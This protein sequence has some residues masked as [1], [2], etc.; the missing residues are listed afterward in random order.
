MN[1]RVLW[2]LPALGLGAGIAVWLVRTGPE[3]ARVTLSQTAIPVEVITAEAR[4]LSPVATGYGI[5]RPARSWH[6]V[7]SVRGGIMSMHP[8]LA[9]GRFIA[10]GAEVLRIDPSEYLLAL[11]EAQADLASLETEAAQIAAER[12]NLD[13][14][15]GIERARL[16]LAEQ[17]LARTGQL[18]A[19]GS[20]PQARLDEQLRATL[21]FR[22][23]V[24]ELENALA[25]LPVQRARLEAQMDRTRVRIARAERDLSLTTLVAPFDM[26]VTDRQVD[27]FQFVSAGQPLLTGEGIAQA[28]IVAQIPIDGFRRIVAA[29]LGAGTLAPLDRMH[30]ADMSG[31]A[32]EVRLVGADVAWPARLSQVEAGLDPRTRTVQVVLSVD[33]PYDFAADGMPLVA[34]MY[35]A[36]DLTG[37][38]L[39][40]HVA[41]PDSAVHD[42]RVLIMDAANR[43]ELRMVEVAFRQGGHT[44]LQGGVAPGELVVLTDVVPAISGTRLRIADRGVAP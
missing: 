29:V 1:L 15:L 34:N 7:A 41:L 25:L 30:G 19:Q 28:E 12:A 27:S 13:G 38:P 5:S 40:P 37:P 9:S 16:A 33:A 18:A 8:D 20:V 26:R 39:A 23:T 4:S 2:L 14:V 43:L 35:L 42:G 44:V 6:A 32:A 36:V 31:V 11:A 17:D 21:A 22:R 3:P 10:A 24:R